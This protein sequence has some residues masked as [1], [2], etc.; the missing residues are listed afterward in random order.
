V[1]AAP[2]RAGRPA[3]AQGCR[4]CT[5]TALADAEVLDEGLEVEEEA[6][7]HAAGVPQERGRGGAG[8]ERSVKER[9]GEG[10]GEQGAVPLERHGDSGA[11]AGVEAGG[12]GGGEASTGPSSK[13]AEEEGGASR[14][15][16]LGRS[17]GRDSG[18]GRG[19]G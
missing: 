8:V 18:K 1:G 14:P 6:L 3:Q 2:G 5:R 19:S 4:R 10:A 13:A 11:G 12:G 15:R 9:G 7:L 16:G 17:E